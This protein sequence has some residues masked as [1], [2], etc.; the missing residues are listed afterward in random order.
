MVAPLV[1]AALRHRCEGNILGNIDC[2]PHDDDKL[3]LV[4]WVYE[5]LI[6]WLWRFPKLPTEQSAQIFKRPI[7]Q[8]SRYPKT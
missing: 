6:L 7:A 5:A 8:S 2:F 4:T 3:T 1:P